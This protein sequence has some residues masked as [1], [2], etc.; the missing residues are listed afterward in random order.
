MLKYLSYLNIF[1]GIIYFAILRS[2]QNYLDL[3]LVLFPILFNWITLYNLI[4]NH[5]K[6]ERWHLIIGFISVL[7]SILSTT[8]SVKLIFEVSI[9]KN[10]I[11]GPPLLLLV[12]RQ[13][14]DCLIILHFIIAYKTNHKILST[15]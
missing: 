3:A 15:N 4:K 1:F 11:L 5:F 10:I 6:F 9:G 12:S 2:Q 14:F 8:I 13:I 7:L